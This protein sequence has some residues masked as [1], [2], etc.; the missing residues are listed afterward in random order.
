MEAKNKKIK[1]I[2]TLVGIC[3]LFGFVVKSKTTLETVLESN[4]SFTASSY[5]LE[6]ATPK[7][8]FATGENA[9]KDTTYL[10]VKKICNYTKIPFSNFYSENLNNKD[11]A[12][13]TSLKTIFIKDASKIKKEGAKK[14]VDF[15]AEGG[16]IIFTNIP[17]NSELNYL[18]GLKKDEDQHT[19]N[20]KAKGIKL[21]KNFLPNANGLN[22]YKEA[23]HDGYNKQSF[24]SSVNVILN[25]SND[26]KYPVLIS[27]TIGLG[28]VLLF[29]SNMDLTK[30][31]RGLL[32][33]SLLSTIEGIPYPVANVSTIFLDDFPSPLYNIKVEPIKSEYNITNQE[34]VNTVW[35]KD[36]QDLADK[37]NIKYTTTI[38]FDYQENTTAPFTFGEWELNRKQNFSVPHLV[39]KN[40]LENKH[41]L[42][43]HGYNHVSLLKRSWTEESIKTS[44]QTVQKKWE[45]N[46]YGDL[47][48]TYIPPTNLIDKMGVK[49]LHNSLPTVK[50]LSSVYLGELEEGG[51][52]EFDV[53]PYEKNI[54][55]FPRISS[56]YYLTDEERYLKESTYLFTGIWSHFIHPDDVY[57][58]PNK[59]NIKTRGDF[60]YR[61][62]LELFW[63]KT[64]KKGL[65]GMFQT[66]DDVLTKH[67]K[68]YPHTK[69]ITVKD[70]GD[71]VVDLRKNDF[72]HI[73]DDKFYSVINMGN[74]S[75][76]KQDW[77]VFAAGENQEQLAN[78]LTKKNIKFH[79]TP[80]HNG[81]LFNISKNSKDLKIPVFRNSNNIRETLA[82]V[83]KYENYTAETAEVEV[84][85]LE[86]LNLKEEAL[87]SRTNVL[88]E[89]GFTKKAWLHYLEKCIW[90]EKEK[91]FWQ[92][93]DAKFNNYP[94]KEVALFS[95]EAAKKAWY[96]SNNEQLKWKDRIISSETN[97]QKKIA[98][99]KE[100]IK[101][102]N[103]KENVTDIVSKLQEIVD[104]DNSVEHKINYINYVLQNDFYE[105]DDILNNLKA[106][107]EYASVATEMI[108]YFSSKNNH[109]KM[110]EWFP[111]DTKM[112]VS[113]KMYLLYNLKEYDL[114]ESYFN[115]LIDANPNNDEAKKIMCDM[116]L[117]QHKFD[118]AWELASTINP[119][120]KDYKDLRDR[121]NYL[122]TTKDVAYQKNKIKKNDNILI[123]RVRD[124]LERA[125]VL[126]ESN[127]VNFISSI[128]TDRSNIAFLDTKASYSI[129]SKNNNLHTISAT[130]TYVNALENV[131][132]P[133]NIDKEVNGLEYEFRNSRRG[134]KNLNY[135]AKARV[136][137][138]NNNNFYYHIGGGINYNLPSTFLS[139]NYT[140]APVRNGAAYNKD[141]YR[142]QLAFYGE[143]LFKNKLTAT[144]YSEYNFYSDNNN[145]FSTSLSVRYPVYTFGKNIFNTVAES[146]VS[147]GSIDQQQGF[148]YFLL[149]DRLYGGG[150]FEY[151]YNTDMDKTFIL[152]D[153]M[154]FS[155]S[156]SKYFSRFRA[157]VNFELK[158]YL[159]F[160][161]NG[162]YYLNNQ[163]YSNSFGLG[164]SYYLK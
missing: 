8:A 121:L 138:D 65:K 114:L 119:S 153:A 18:L 149:K 19:F 51:D 24:T 102:F 130:K 40:V 34:F 43:L 57:Q 23:K 89:K 37:F 45:L 99:L 48:V 158:K 115:N 84:Q 161:F 67:T 21:A 66:F 73:K 42:G 78:Y 22:L 109:Q 47:P 105:K 157:R 12:I 61:N 141:I 4:N 98:L 58:I 52:R 7:I 97:P 123:E 25:A 86:P 156:Y 104:L 120:Y 162:E 135:S 10:N 17:Y 14:L 79:K 137:T 147:K 85:P 31:E 145:L 154:F 143:R 32:F 155:D 107:K 49:A 29:N 127:S 91:L 15:T 63:K 144:L 11:F 76:D 33:S 53:D 93:L 62:G 5:F 72:K 87:L 36:M 128:S 152:A 95:E 160:N 150:G 9:D 39:T 164:V 94:T 30:H 81:F 68:T 163:Y 100:Y 38:I 142:N 90:L 80:I 2:A 110:V 151:R 140:T 55:D 148:P 124:S 108:W 60:S 20:N 35:W 139:L 44:F 106:E 83:T 132:N 112:L 136:E 92:D 122:L 6:S 131:S 71:L 56:G 54:F 101:N 118:E 26:K 64:N 3:V 46:N 88:N 50:Y 103:T 59:S 133:E 129:T 125:I 16:S 70:A 126:E 146:L 13:P 111:F 1:T 117:E 28:K 159:I 41:E 75:K 74:S 27:N 77:F 69:F 134:L 96:T 113:N 82:A 116:Y